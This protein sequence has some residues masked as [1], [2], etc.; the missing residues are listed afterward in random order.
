MIRELISVL[1]FLF[2]AATAGSQSEATTTIM[3]TDSTCQRLLEK[4][5]YYGALD[6]F[7]QLV[8]E[9]EDNENEDGY[10][11]SKYHL[12][13]V[14]H[15]LDYIRDAA[16]MAAQCAEYF[17][18]ND[19]ARTMASKLL[20]A[21]SYWDLGESEKSQSVLSGISRKAKEEA[22]M[23]HTMEY[24]TLRARH[25]LRSGDT[26]D[27]IS[28]I[29]YATEVCLHQ[30][31]TSIYPHL[32]YLQGTTYLALGQEKDGLKS[33]LKAAKV[34]KEIN[35]LYLYEEI[36]GEIIGI[37]SKFHRYERAFNLTQERLSI[38]DS[39][40][41]LKKE[42]IASRMIAK[43]DS[44]KKQNTI[45][46][47]E[48]EQRATQL[49]TRR[50]SLANYAL[51]ISFLAVLAAAYMI[52]TFYQQKLSSNQIITTQKEMINQQKIK[53][54]EN[55]LQIESMQSMMKGQEL[56][57]ER[58]AKDLH[59][60]LG[61]MLSAI[62]LKFDA[63]HYDNDASAQHQADHENLQELLD[64]ACQEV[65][66]ISSNLQPG[67]LEQLGLIEAISDLVNKFERNTDLEIHFQ[68]YGIMDN[69]RLDSFSSLN[70]YRIVQ[71]LL[72]NV[73]KHAQASEVIVQLNRESNQLTIMVEDDGIGYNPSDI[74]EGMGSENV[75]SRVNFLKG[76][77]NIDSVKGEGT[78]TLITFPV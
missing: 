31:I 49:K 52:I 42:E 22:D 74:K 39:L 58:V 63:L 77:L 15:G 45:F 8:D 46:D 73:M 4:Y 69:K 9:Y 35:N 55:D 78:T 17:K 19:P 3:P 34:A 40:F 27:A 76:D 75:R 18:G 70:V 53:E 60:S 11:T 1:V 44:K 67:A 37:L 28:T 47:L 64:D 26:S 38:R 25:Q 5:D 16:G 10:Y 33:L 72:N 21:Q 6:C 14:Y 68:H 62:K 43:Y 13:K 7:L 23:V 12:A 56:E 65:R 61:G 71:E 20:L 29:Q 54:L 51:M 32:Q 48:G 41:S 30:D 59:D 36:A 2:M 24:Y 57:R 50:S 66:N